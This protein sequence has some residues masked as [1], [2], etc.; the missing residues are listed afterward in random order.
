M[1]ITKVKINNSVSV[2][3]GLNETISYH[4]SQGK[5]KKILPNLELNELSTIE[6]KEFKEGD[7]LLLKMIINE[8]FLKVVAQIY[9]KYGEST[10][11]ILPKDKMLLIKNNTCSLG[12]PL[13][14]D[15]VGNK[16]Y[17]I[18]KIYFS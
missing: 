18:K 7:V 11:I 12:A 17:D 5:L 13:M 2:I 6:Y 10:F 1:N 3:N 16:I 15:E 8:E 4:D 14:I 9:K